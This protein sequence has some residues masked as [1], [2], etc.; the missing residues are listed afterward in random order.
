MSGRALP[1]TALPPNPTKPGHRRAAAGLGRVSRLLSYSTTRRLTTVCS[2]VFRRRVYT[3]G[4]HRAAQRHLPHEVAGY[5]KVAGGIGHGI[6]QLHGAVA[7]GL[8]LGTMS[9]CQGDAY[10]AA[11]RTA[12]PLSTSTSSRRVV[13]VDKARRGRAPPAR[14]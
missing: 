14:G 11:G 9:C 2:P 12:R 3:A 8:V 5:H 10:P 7:V 13:I 4:K 6:L 1:T